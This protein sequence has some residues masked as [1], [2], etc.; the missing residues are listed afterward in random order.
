M[1]M[2][3]ILQN[4]F[5]I[6]IVFD[7]ICSIVASLGTLTFACTDLLVTIFCVVRQNLKDHNNLKK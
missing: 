3:G 1:S 6:Y 7:N 2:C 4:K 5:N